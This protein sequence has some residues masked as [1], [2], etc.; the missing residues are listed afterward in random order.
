MAIWYKFLGTLSKHSRD[1]TKCKDETGACMASPF[2]IKQVVVIKVES[3]NPRGISPSPIRRNRCWIGTLLVGGGGYWRISLAQCSQQGVALTPRGT[4]GNVW[5][6]IW[7]SYLRRECCSCHLV[8]RGQ[9]GCQSF[10]NA[11]D[12]PQKRMIWTTGQW[13]NYLA[14]AATYLAGPNAK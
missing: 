6:P 10:S 9:R 14:G 7:L 3:K 12:N 13:W 11:Q 2:L 4:L 5:G 8:G 1:R